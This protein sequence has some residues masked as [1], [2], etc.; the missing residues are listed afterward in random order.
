MNIKTG[1]LKEIVSKDGGSMVLIPAGEFIM[2]SAQGP[3]SF[4][5][6]CPRHKVFL[7]AYY[8]D[9]YAVTVGQYRKFCAETGRE[10][11]SEPSWV[12][13]D[14]HPVVNVFWDDATAYANHYGKRLPTE[15]EWE[16]AARAGSATSYCF[17]D[18]E[19]DLKDYAWYS[20]NSNRQTH[21]VGTRKPNAFGLYDMHGNALEWCS[22][23]FDANYYSSSPASNP[24]GPDSGLNRVARGGCW[25][26]SAT[27]YCRSAVRSGYFL[28]HVDSN[29]G[30]RCACSP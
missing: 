2:G 22:D 29:I 7:S 12:W 14:T 5:N 11:P 30:F 9:K 13:Q 26:G 3:D 16:K 17:G 24:K 20:A 15:A 27:D 19:S 18:A 23:W 25:F 21:P 4:E 10:M 28:V 1:K 8:I 6:E